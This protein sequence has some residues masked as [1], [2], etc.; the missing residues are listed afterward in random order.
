MEEINPQTIYIKLS[1]TNHMNDFSSVGYQ[2]SLITAALI[3]SSRL[4]CV[5]VL[6]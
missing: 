3:R 6:T 1:T 2:L 4:T 5:R